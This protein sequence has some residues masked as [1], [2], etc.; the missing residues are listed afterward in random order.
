M[1]DTETAL[2]QG[3]NVVAPWTVVTQTPE[4]GRLDV[5]VRPTDLLP[6]VRALTEA[7]WGYLSAITGLDV[8]GAGQPTPEEKQWERLDGVPEHAGTVPMGGFEVLYHFCH[9]AAVLTLRVRLPRTQAAVV[10]ICSVIPTA[11]VFERELIEM[12]GIEVTE[13]PN[14]DHLLLPDDWPSGVYPLRKEFHAPDAG[15]AAGEQGG[16]HQ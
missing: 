1:M 4:Q 10:S 13:T 6:A 5:V 8:P 7:H 3:S 12:L 9:G 11:T 16:S 14:S 2:A 15:S